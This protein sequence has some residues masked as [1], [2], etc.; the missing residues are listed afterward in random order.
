VWRDSWAGRRSGVPT[1]STAQSFVCWCFCGFCPQ[2]ADCSVVRF[3]LRLRISPK[4]EGQEPLRTKRCFS[5]SVPLMVSR[6]WGCSTSMEHR[7]GTAW[8]CQLCPAQRPGAL[9]TAGAAP[10][11]LRW[12]GTQSCARSGVLT[13]YRNWLV[14]NVFTLSLSS[15]IIFFNSLMFSQIYLAIVKSSTLSF[16]ISGWV[17]SC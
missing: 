6:A 12:Q 14:C 17:F 13:G 16:S 7:V 4:F 2:Q 11:S 1:I 5:V 8:L 9:P 15:S 10:S 3:C